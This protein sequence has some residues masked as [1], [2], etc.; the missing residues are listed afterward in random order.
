MSCAKL[1]TASSELATNLLRLLSQPALAGAGS[2]GE[3][4]PR[5]YRQGGGDEGEIFS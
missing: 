5:I 2:L 4:Q 1:S 3:L